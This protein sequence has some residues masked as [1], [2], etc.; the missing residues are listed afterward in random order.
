MIQLGHA[1][2]PMTSNHVEVSEEEMREAMSGFAGLLPRPVVQNAQI[3][4]CRLFRSWQ[5]AAA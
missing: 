4:Q 1:H 3:V 5:A 2:L